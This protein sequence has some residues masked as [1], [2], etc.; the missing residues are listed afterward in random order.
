MHE[1]EQI[2]AETV[3]SFKSQPFIGY[4]MTRVGRYIEVSVS[5]QGGETSVA[6]NWPGLGHMSAVATAEFAADLAR[7][8]HIAQHIQLLLARG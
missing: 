8:S 4:A 3:T 5:A 1:I 2:A 7:A 6:I